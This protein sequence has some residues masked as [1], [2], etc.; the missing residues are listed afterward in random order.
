MTITG[1]PLFGDTPHVYSTIIKLYWL[2]TTTHKLYVQ[3]N[4]VCQLNTMI[5]F[6]HGSHISVE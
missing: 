5:S 4:Y 2:E 3:T 6:H 1:M